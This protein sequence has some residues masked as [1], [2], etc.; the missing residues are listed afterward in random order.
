MLSLVRSQFRVALLTDR[1]RLISFE[2]DDRHLGADLYEHSFGC[3]SKTA[4]T[5]DGRP[6]DIDSV[7]LIG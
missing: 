6:A 5:R 3:V 2:V 4:Q 7:R 1:Q